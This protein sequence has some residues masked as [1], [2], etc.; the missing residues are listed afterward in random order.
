MHMNTHGLPTCDNTTVPKHTQTDTH[1]IVSKLEQCVHGVSSGGQ[2]KDEG[3]TAVGVSKRFG[4][5]EWWG[6]NVLLTSFGHYKVLNS[7]NN[8]KRSAYNSNM[9]VYTSNAKNPLHIHVLQL[10]TSVYRHCTV[11]TLSGLKTLTIMSFW[12]NPK[13]SFHFPGSFSA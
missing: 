10:C 2:H 8:L 12:K 6:L 4:E 3:S 7:R 11:C 13:D 9:N 5:V 1:L